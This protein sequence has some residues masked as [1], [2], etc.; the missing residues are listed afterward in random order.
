MTWDQVGIML[1]GMVAVILSQLP[2]DNQR[3][4]YA[5]LFG[6]CG[7]PFWFWA[8][9]KAQQIGILIVTVGYTYGWA[10]GI[11]NHWIKQY[12]VKT[13][14][15]EFFKDFHPTKIP[16]RKLDLNA[17]PVVVSSDQFRALRAAQTPLAP[18]T[19]GSKNPLFGGKLG[20][21]IEG[22]KLGPFHEAIA[23]SRGQAHESMAFL[24]RSSSVLDH[25][26]RAGIVPLDK[27]ISGNQPIR[28]DYPF[29]VDQK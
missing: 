18:S 19:E 24:D 1:T 13:R 5:C 15:D 16:Q 10:L 17:I 29:D 11:W 2:S 8:A 22:D 3:R 21:P 27:P 23:S 20:R 7:Q 26:K 14:V 4:R 12:L 9:W 28:Q 25:A 6:M